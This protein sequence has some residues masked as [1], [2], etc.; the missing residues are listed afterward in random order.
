VF[1]AA[2]PLEVFVSISVRDPL[3][4]P[5]V[6]AAFAGGVDDAASSCREMSGGRM[7]VSSSEVRR[8]SATDV[9]VS[10]GGPEVL[11]AAVYV[12][13]SG[14]ISGHAILMLPPADARGL[15]RI[16][17]AG[18]PEETGGLDVGVDPAH[19]QDGGLT[20][21]ERSALE[22]VGN[23]AVSAILS[24]L[25]D[26]LGEPIHPTVPVFVFDMAGAVLDGIVSE[27]V[28]PDEMLFAARTRFAQDDRDATGVLLVVPARRP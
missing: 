11:V 5:A 3:D 20:N 15:A 2:S 14:A 18:L 4:D 9:L 16:V 1:N 24:R 6:L 27:A 25:G 7:R 21:L 22:E 17:L 26:H 13:F 12:G 8:L 28:G 19:I 10:A 23:V